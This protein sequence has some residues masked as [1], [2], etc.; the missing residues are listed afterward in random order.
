VKRERAELSSEA[1]SVVI[2]LLPPQGRR[3][4]AAE[5]SKPRARLRSLEETMNFFSL[6]L[7]LGSALVLRESV[8]KGDDS[9]FFPV[10]CGLFLLS[11]VLPV[12]ARQRG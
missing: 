12:A 5:E 6:V 7:F 2:P 11:I 1:A 10:G 3:R 8:L 4:A 9:P